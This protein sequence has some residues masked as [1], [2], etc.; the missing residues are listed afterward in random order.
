[1]AGKQRL[2]KEEIIQV[3]VYL[4]TVTDFRSAHTHS[5]WN[6]FL[7][8]AVIESVTGLWFGDILEE[9]LIVPLGLQSEKPSPFDKPD[10]ATAYFAL[11]DGRF[12]L[13][14]K[15]DAKHQANPYVYMVA[16]SSLKRSLYALIVFLAA[17]TRQRVSGARMTP[18]T[19]FFRLQ[20]NFESHTPEKQLLTSPLPNDS[21]DLAGGV[22]GSS[23]S[24][25]GIRRSSTSGNEVYYG[26]ERS[27]G[28]CTTYFPVPESRSGVVLFTSSSPTIDLTGLIGR[29]MVGIL[30]GQRADAQALNN[31]SNQAASVR[32]GSYQ[33]L[34]SL[35]NAQKQPYEPLGMP[36]GAFEGTY[37]NSTRKLSFIIDPTAV[38]LYVKVK[39]SSRSGYELRHLSGTKFYWPPVYEQDL[40]QGTDHGVTV[41]ERVVQFVVQDSS[42]VGLRWRMDSRLRP[43]V[44]SKIDVHGKRQGGFRFLDLPSE[45]RNMVYLWAL[46]TLSGSIDLVRNGNGC[47]FADRVSPRDKHVGPFNCIKKHK[48]AV[49]EGVPR[50]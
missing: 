18:G 36:L 28:S 7:L 47:F 13:A 37:R 6:D 26:T 16:K 23:S 2:T 33:S 24:C 50:S 1:M 42:V 35:L 5:T 38:G 49:D 44:F 30:F 40:S 41:E 8:Q 48:L 19:P 25:L 22:A 29:Q 45:I 34:G 15:D 20:T 46:K 10:T 32:T 31:S 27:I 39:G 11:K 9:S 17:Y 14:K 12:A 4:P 43:E 21:F 3:A